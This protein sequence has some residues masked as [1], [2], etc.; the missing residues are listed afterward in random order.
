MDCK[1]VLS[2]LS[3]FFDGELAEDTR[4]TVAEHLHDCVRCSQTLEDFKAL[5]QLL[6]LKEQLTIVP[7]LWTRTAAELRAG[8]RPEPWFPQ[9]HTPWAAAFVST[10]L[11]IGSLLFIGMKIIPNGRAESEQY[12]S[13][14]SAQTELLASD[15]VVDANQLSKDTLLSII[16]SNND[17]TEIK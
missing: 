6:K 3:P 2:L 10:V 9:I 7:S 4:V 17:K 14:E 12:A 8:G 16:L 11:L 5:R 13:S 1:K 15:F